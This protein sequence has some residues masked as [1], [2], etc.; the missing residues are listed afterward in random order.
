M[1]KPTVWA[2]YVLEGNNTESF[3][4]LWCQNSLILN[5][6]IESQSQPVNATGGLRMATKKSN[7]TNRQT[8]DSF[9][10]LSIPMLFWIDPCCDL[11][12]CLT[13]S[14]PWIQNA[15]VGVARWASPIKTT[16]LMT[17]CILTF[18]Y[19]TTATNESFYAG[20]SGSVRGRGRRGGGS[21]P[22]SL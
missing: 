4:V 8:N 21:Y 12:K 20:P 10:V 17:F 14:P 9:N 1:I 19:T 2:C 15:N 3:S 11:G 18:R 22:L 6:S 5:L 16:H 13:R 7:P